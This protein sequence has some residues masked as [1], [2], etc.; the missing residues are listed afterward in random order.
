LLDDSLDVFEIAVNVTQGIHSSVSWQWAGGGFRK[1]I[2]PNQLAA[3]IGQSQA[4]TAALW[5]GKMVNADILNFG[6]QLGQY[7]VGAE[8]TASLLGTLAARQKHF[9]LC[10]ISADVPIITNLPWEALLLPGTDEPLLFHP[11][12]QG[13]FDYAR[14][15][16]T[17]LEF[18]GRRVRQKCLTISSESSQRDLNVQAQV[19]ELNQ[20]LLHHPQIRHRS[21]INPDVAAL[22][23]ALRREC[24]LFLYAGHGHLV[25]GSYKIDLQTTTVDVNTLLEGLKLSRAEILIFDSC[26]S[27][28]GSTTN[29]LPALLWL[30]PSTT[31]ILGMQGPANDAVSCWYMPTIIERLMLGQPVWSCVNAMRMLLYDH[32]SDAWILPVMHLKQTYRP[33]ETPQAQI[34]KE[35]L[36]SL[37]RVL[38]QRKSSL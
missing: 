2:E 28:Y 7:V 21:F 29:G 15:H 25:E 22:K 6:R 33:L 31:C 24:T 13:S 16:D 17:G 37:D 12:V 32:S 11:D 18:A 3:L 19:D 20:R 35:Y 5:N 8:N 30:L 4:L 36:A 14:I 23:I 38:Q 9:S 34:R 1:T 27:G 10:L 26:E